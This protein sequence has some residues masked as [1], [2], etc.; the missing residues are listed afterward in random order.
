MAE[1]FMDQRTSKQLLQCVVC[2]D[3]YE[4]GTIYLHR[5]MEHY[6]LED[7][8]SGNGFCPDHEHLRQQ[9]FIAMIVVNKPLLKHE[10]PNF[11][12]CGEELHELRTGEIFFIKKSQFRKNFSMDPPSE[13][14]AFMSADAFQAYRNKQATK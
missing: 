7:T 6:E 11:G 14:Y 10:L 2:G 1:L 12:A 3:L 5:D 8:C 9:G 4:S 13:Q